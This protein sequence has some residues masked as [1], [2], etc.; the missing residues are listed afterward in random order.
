METKHRCKDFNSRLNVV[1]FSRKI[2]IGKITAEKNIN[3]LWMLRQVAV[4][5]FK[6]HRVYFIT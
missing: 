4:G 3:S 6:V 1:F 5:Y 2:D